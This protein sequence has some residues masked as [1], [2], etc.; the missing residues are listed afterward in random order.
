[1]DR[2]DIKTLSSE[3]GVQFFKDT[4]LA[5][6]GPRNY[7]VANCTGLNRFPDKSEGNF[8]R[9]L[10]ANVF[11][12]QR[13][14]ILSRALGCPSFHLSTGDLDRKAVT[15]N[16]NELLEELYA[17]LDWH[18]ALIDGASRGLSRA[19][20][21]ELNK[22]DHYSVSKMLM[23]K[24]C[25][26][27]DGASFVRISNFFGVNIR[28]RGL[29]PRLID[30]RLRGSQISALNEKRNWSHEEELGPF[31]TSLCLGQ[32]YSK[33]RC[34][35]GYGSYDKTAEEIFEQVCL[36]LP[37]CY[38]T[39]NFAPGSIANTAN[40][41]RLW[42]QTEIMRGTEDKFDTQM[43]KVVRS[44]RQLSNFTGQDCLIDGSELKK[45]RYEGTA[46][47]SIASKIR[48]PIRTMIKQ[49]SRG[50]YEGAGL[51][52]I[53][54]EINFYEALGE[55]RL[56]SLKELYPKVISSKISASE[57][58][59]ELAYIGKGKSISDIWNEQGRVLSSQTMSVVR[60]LFDRSYLKRLRC[61]ELNEGYRLLDALYFDRAIDRLMNLGKLTSQFC[62]DPTFA[63]L[64]RNLSEGSDLIISGEP[65]ENPIKLLRKIR[66][67]EQLTSELSPRTVG[68]CGHGDLTIL[69]MIYDDSQDRVL[70]IDPRGH[71]G[72]WDAA[73][74]VGK[75]LFSLGGFAQIMCGRLQF[76][77][78]DDGS[79]HLEQPDRSLMKLREEVLELVSSHSSF[80]QI[81]LL[82]RSAFLKRCLLSE[83]THFLADAGYRFFQ[84]LDTTRT[85]SVI[86]RGAICLQELVK[87]L[88]EDSNESI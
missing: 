8:E 44:A 72:E 87:L 3:T 40:I 83:A 78:D 51:A 75:L 31:L 67:S 53:G 43:R 35:W 61:V 50:G 11:V 26:K 9:T 52:K 15:S 48:T 41:P 49:A 54:A 2:N 27:F 86:A 46:G 65:V 60:C 33:N 34:Y 24:I 85:A 6:F 66:C 59:L 4:L 64:I 57:A 70:L 30:A 73:Y 42:D 20:Q 56:N 69:N 63:K 25:H 21:R 76:Q 13:L 45:A 84:G 17:S 88:E 62:L 55:D 14:L 16:E 71:V 5:R 47:G 80:S 81:R 82:E 77:W 39:V 22:S 23:E 68:P 36:Y 29:I 10:S 12:T 38:G 58:S 74:D 79:L 32:M 7:F 28:R 18:E 37:T 1:M 19:N